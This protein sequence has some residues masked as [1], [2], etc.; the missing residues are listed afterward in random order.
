MREKEL[1]F[2]QHDISKRNGPHP[3]KAMDAYSFKSTDYGLTF[4]DPSG[5]VGPGQD[6]YWQFGLAKEE[7]CPE[8]GFHFDVMPVN[9]TTGKLFRGIQHKAGSI[10]CCFCCKDTGLGP[11][12]D[13]GC[14]ANM[15]HNWKHTD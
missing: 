4:I 8:G 2:N 6:D 14:N 10:V 13:L 12:V 11:R 7:T 15:N 9:K 3:Q 5:K 1:L